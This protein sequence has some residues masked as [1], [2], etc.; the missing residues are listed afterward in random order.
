MAQFDNRELR[1]LMRA[2]AQRIEAADERFRRTHE[3]LPLDVVRADA[4]H[5][6]PDGVQLTEAQLDAY[7]SA[8]SAGDPFQF[9][10]GG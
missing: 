3:G 8:V 1:N 9:Q 4:I 6:L 10:L 5:A 7:A 2:I